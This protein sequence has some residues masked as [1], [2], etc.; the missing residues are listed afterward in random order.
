MRRTRFA[1]RPRRSRW[2]L[3]LLALSLTGVAVL[4]VGWHFADALVWA[5]SVRRRTPP[6]HVF[7]VQGDQQTPDLEVQPTAHPT[8]LTLTRN[9]ATIRAGVLGLEWD[10]PA[11][12]RYFAQLGPV[13]EQ[14]R[15]TVTRA[16][17]WQEAALPVGQQVRPSTV[18]LGTPASRRL[19]YQDVLVPAEH[20]AMPAWLVPGDEGGEAAGT[21]WVIVTHGYKGLRQ[22]A[23]RILPTFARLGISSLT[24][25]YRN[26]HG[27]PRTRQGVYRLSAEEWEDLEAA[28]HYARTHGARRLLLM[29]FSMGGGITLAFLRYST[30]APLISG[31][32]LDSPPLEWRTL[33][34]HYAR[35]YRLLPFAG[36]V[37]WLTAFKSGQDF[38]AIDHHS[39]M[40]QFTTPML[41]F[42]GS[43]DRTVPVAHVERLAHARPDIVEYHRVEGAE[44][45]RPWNIDP[46]AYEAML[47]RFVRRVLPEAPTDHTLAWSSKT[48]GT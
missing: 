18:G 34:R 39:V 46:E 3:V 9:S 19:K 11:G 13:V 15:R 41:L 42:H 44:H 28:V 30:L 33:I 29:G 47:T 48:E 7:G 4:R 14:T 6:T 10:D 23:L 26:A 20:G 17:Q 12:V 5:P 21:D 31:V 16:V 35:R 8:R 43:A 32:I 25:T 36:M 45:V 38:D 24:I 1:P 37:E 27:A 40:E 2:P 22:D